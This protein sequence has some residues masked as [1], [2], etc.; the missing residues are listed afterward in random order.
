[1]VLKVAVRS[2][3]SQQ[4]DDRAQRSMQEFW[5][6]RSG[7]SIHVHTFYG[8]ELGHMTHRIAREAGKRS[9]ALRPG[10][11]RTG[12]GALPG[13]FHHR[14]LAPSPPLASPGPSLLFTCSHIG[15]PDP[16]LLPCPTSIILQLH[17]VQADTQEKTSPRGSERHTEEV[18]SS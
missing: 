11:R 7:N 2:A 10:G 8:P 4:T 3:S 15:P 13:S 6:A 16:K 1:M 5:G 18:Y 12:F 14:P 9:P 17:P